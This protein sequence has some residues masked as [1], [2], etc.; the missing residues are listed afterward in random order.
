MSDMICFI[1]SLVYAFI[2]ICA[3]LG[4]TLETNDKRADIIYVTFCIALFWPIFAAFVV[5]E[6]VAKSRAKP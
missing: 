5:G 6:G 1:A 2:G 4:Y 3:A